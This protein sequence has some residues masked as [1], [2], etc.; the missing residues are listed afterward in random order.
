MDVIV[1]DGA[2]NLVA[3]TVPIVGPS[4]PLDTIASADPIG[5]VVLIAVAHPDPLEGIAVAVATAAP[6]AAE[7]IA[8]DGSE[9][10][11]TS[12]TSPEALAPTGS[13]ETRIERAIHALRFGDVK[14]GGVYIPCP[15]KAGWMIR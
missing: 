4:L 1:F 5:T 15:V 9:G 13:V 7:G 6:G 8:T 14:S 3:A 2:G 10:I 12:G 11:A